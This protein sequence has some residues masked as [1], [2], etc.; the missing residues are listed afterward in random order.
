MIIVFKYQNIISLPFLNYFDLF[1]ISNFR[2]NLFY[3]DLSCRG[4][5]G[6]F[7]FKPLDLVQM[8]AIGQSRLFRRTDI[9]DVDMPDYNS[10][11]TSPNNNRK[12]YSRTF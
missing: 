11:P 1:G 3:G 2:N 5:Y 8:M 12:I 4:E 6:T 9:N 7:C 10:P